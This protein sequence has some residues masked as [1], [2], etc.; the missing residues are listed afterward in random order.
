[1]T[2]G[3]LNTCRRGRGVYLA[4]RSGEREGPIAKQW[5]GEG[6]PISWCNNDDESYANDPLVGMKGN[7]D[8][9]HPPNA[10]AL[11]PSL[12]PLTRGE[13]KMRPP[14]P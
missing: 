5:E 13:G 10:D 14:R 6:R 11:G 3:L 2:K 4:P 7:R 1:M 12:S 8:A 9:P